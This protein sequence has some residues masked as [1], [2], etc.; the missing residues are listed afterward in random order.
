MRR[1]A[2]TL[3]VLIAVGLSAGPAVAMANPPGVYTP[4]GDQVFDYDLCGQFV[5]YP[6]RCG[7]L[8]AP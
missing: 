3:G 4:P 1:I 5:G 7:P 2:A 8:F 6:H